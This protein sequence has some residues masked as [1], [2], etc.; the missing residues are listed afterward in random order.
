ML[1]LRM[2]AILGCDTE[3]IRLNP[4]EVA[5][6]LA[7]GG[8]RDG[9]DV[10]WKRG[11]SVDVSMSIRFKRVADPRPR[12]DGGKPSERWEMEVEINSSST[13]RG[14]INTISVA[15]LLRDVAELG[16]ILQTQ[17]DAWIVPVA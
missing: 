16:A 8:I 1:A 2:P 17:W 3:A 6:S 4:A 11:W 14:I 5:S 10:A 7:R 15:A 9:F 13:R 12:S